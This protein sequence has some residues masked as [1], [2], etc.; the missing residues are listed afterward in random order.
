MIDVRCKGCNKL[1]AKA[2]SMNAA[3][4]CPS[5]HMIFEYKVFSNLFVTN[6]YDNSLHD[7]KESAT[8]L[9]ESTRP[10]ALEQ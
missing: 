6:Q 2:D 8:I 10:S 9:S 7:K 1:L 3:I 5:C 4:K